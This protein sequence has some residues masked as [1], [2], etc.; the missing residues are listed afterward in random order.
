V[1]IRVKNVFYIQNIGY[2]WNSLSLQ[3]CYVNCIVRSEPIESKSYKIS[4]CK[5]QHKKG[6]LFNISIGTVP[7]LTHGLHSNFSWVHDA[8][9]STFCMTMYLSVTQLVITF[10]MTMYIVHV[11]D[12]IMYHIIHD[13][14]PVCNSNMYHILQANLPVFNSI[15][16]HILHDCVLVCNSIMYHIL[17]DNAPVCNS[18]MNHILHDNLPVF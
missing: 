4:P 14:L 3:S 5:V 15:M 2:I 9:S 1:R 6:C 17:H 18:I 8:P 12:S 7:A 11:F 10:C 13:N 16:Y